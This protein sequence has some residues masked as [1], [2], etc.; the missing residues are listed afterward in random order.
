MANSI[1][2]DLVDALLADIETLIAERDEADEPL[3]E[4][5]GTMLDAGAFAGFPGG[6]SRVR[7]PVLL[8]S[9]IKYQAS[10]DIELFPAEP[11]ILAITRTV[12]RG[13]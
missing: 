8:D 6:I 10:G 1:E 3:V 11:D 7:H 5:L 2:D 13:S 12:A 4:I 9:M